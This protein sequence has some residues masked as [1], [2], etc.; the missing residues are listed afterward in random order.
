MA[1]IVSNK[2]GKD[3]SGHEAMEMSNTYYTGPARLSLFGTLKSPQTILKED[4]VVYTSYLCSNITY[5]TS[6]HNKSV[7]GRSQTER[8]FCDSKCILVQSSKPKLSNIQKLVWDACY[9]KL[10]SVQCL[11]FKLLTKLNSAEVIIITT[12]TINSHHDTHRAVVIV[13]SICNLQ[14]KVVGASLLPVQWSGHHQVPSIQPNVKVVLWIPICKTKLL[15]SWIY[16]RITNKGLL[17]FS[18]RHDFCKI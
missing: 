7:T 2:T 9:H 14:R 3:I 12:T 11:F 6:V 10:H 17:N 15:P 13:N 16:L 8:N 18:F 5:I 1:D 4:G